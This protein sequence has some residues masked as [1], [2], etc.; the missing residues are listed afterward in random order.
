[1]E[2]ELSREYNSD[3]QTFN[4]KLLKKTEFQLNHRRIFRIVDVYNQGQIFI[5][6][7]C[8]C[9]FQEFDLI[10]LTS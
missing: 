6:N 2:I 4:S 9:F 3:R 10:Y 5:S 7:V 8:V 1:M